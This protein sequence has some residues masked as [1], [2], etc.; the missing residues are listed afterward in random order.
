MDGWMDGR[1]M[2]G[3]ED[4]RRPWRHPPENRADWL[5]WGF[6]GRQLQRGTDQGQVLLHERAAGGARVTYSRCT[7]QV[8]VS[9]LRVAAGG[10]T[11]LPGQARGDACLQSLGSHQ[12]TSGRVQCELGGGRNAGPMPSAALPPAGVFGSGRQRACEGHSGP[13]LVVYTLSCALWAWRCSTRISARCWPGAQEEQDAQGHAQDQGR[14]GPRR[15]PGIRSQDRAP[16][17][18]PEANP[19]G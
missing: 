6:L 12:P 14:Q 13:A 17:G 1:M 16:P 18:S 10:P 8:T 9:T 3:E 15:R 19:V 2:G 11:R 7:T 5:T 4:E